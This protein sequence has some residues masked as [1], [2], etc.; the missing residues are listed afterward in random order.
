MSQSTDL[1]FLDA[2]I[3]I[4]ALLKGD[5]RHPEAYPIVEKAR[6]GELLTVT[7][8]GVLSEVYAALTWIGA[9]P[10]QSP[11]VAS[12]VVSLL[13]EAP[14]AIQVLETNLEAGLKMLELAATHRLTAR[15]I[16]D[17]RHAATAI[18]GG[19][20]RVYTYDVEDWQIFESD[21]IIITGPP[22]VLS[23]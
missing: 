22:S 1:I 6:Q 12:Q 19:I 15:R 13:V 16:H 10:P 17:A 18:I 7:S 5:P 2:G 20:S 11:D 21:G 14:S 3:F 4:G 9:Q 23:G 8:V